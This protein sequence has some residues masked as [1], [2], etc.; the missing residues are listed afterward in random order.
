MSDLRRSIGRA[1]TWGTIAV[2]LL[3]PSRAF[4]QDVP[5]APPELPS[6]AAVAAHAGDPSR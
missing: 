1:G 4:A 2:A 6:P 5:P 3:T